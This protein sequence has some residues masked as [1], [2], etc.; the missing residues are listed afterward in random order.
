[1]ADDTCPHCQHAVDPHV[2]VMTSE[3]R[4]DGG[5]MF[6]PE[7]D[8]RCVSTWGTNNNPPK[9]VPEPEEVE[10]LRLWVQEQRN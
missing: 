2:L 8:C 3:A 9:R 7:P 4:D 5:M 10:R 1:M 6:C